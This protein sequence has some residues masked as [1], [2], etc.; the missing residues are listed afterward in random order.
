MSK[1]QGKRSSAS[2]QVAIYCRISKAP[3]G[4]KVTDDDASDSVE[5]QRAACLKRAKVEKW[6]VIET[7][8]DDD[9]SASTKSKK[10]RPAY[11]RM[12]AD[13]EA[14]K[15]GRILAYSNSRLTRRPLELEALIGL[16]DRTGVIVSTVVSGDDNLSTADGRMVARIKASVDAAEAE[17]ISERVKAQQAQMRAAGRYQTRRAFGW[18]KAPKG[19]ADPPHQAE[20]EL[21]QQAIKD[22]TNRVSLTSIVRAWNDA[23]VT[24]VTGVPWTIPKL[25]KVLMRPRNAGLVEHQGQII[26]DVTGVW[27]P[28]CT[29][30]EW[31]ALCG[32][33]SDARRTTNTGP[34]PTTLLSGIA[35]CGVCGSSLHRSGGKKAEGPTYR[36][37]SSNRAPGLNRCYNS[38]NIELVD[39]WVVRVL[40]AGVLS[41]RFTAPQGPDDDTRRKLTEVRAKRGEVGERMAALQG[42]LS[43]AEI[44]LQPLLK[45]IADLQKQYDALSAEVVWL[46]G[47]D[48]AA[49]L[50]G[51]VFKLDEHAGETVRE[52]L[53]AAVKD[54]QAIRSAW[55]GLELGQ[56]RALLRALVDVEV[57]SSQ[58]NKVKGTARVL[59]TPRKT[60]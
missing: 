12:L 31:E 36:C 21:L 4:P 57:V 24:T 23:G 25:R 56:Q 45:A 30:E 32:V 46:E 15:F 38:I 47:A 29:R 27:E 9:I 28:V 13:A 1:R 51:R 55:D 2:E 39:W 10:P 14:G 50:F 40:L 37:T 7:Y 34:T 18:E 53:G 20:F 5:R 48:P 58:K 59:V 17:R 35:R 52:Q 6:A 26:P 41:G 43:K 16:H 60:E 54:A 3:K 44:P 19:E 33:L 11:A 22:A 49:D 8:V 42:Q